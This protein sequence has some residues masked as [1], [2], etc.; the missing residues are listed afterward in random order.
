MSI[1]A[2]NIK[3]NSGHLIQPDRAV[4]TLDEWEGAL[5]DIASQANELA[6]IVLKDKETIASL[7]FEVK[8]LKS[9]LYEP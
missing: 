2:I 1:E 9:Q 4:I 5:S 3:F 7:R 6:A 8:A